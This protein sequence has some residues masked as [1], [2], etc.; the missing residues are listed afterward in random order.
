VVKVNAQ[1]VMTL[2]RLTDLPVLMCRDALVEADGDLQAAIRR[3]RASP[4]FGLHTSDEEVAA[5]LSLNG[6]VFAPAE[7]QPVILP[8]GEVVGAL[9][10]SGTA[11]ADLFLIDGLVCS[12]NA[13]GEL[14]GTRVDNEDLSASIKAFLR[15]SGVPEYP[16]LQA[17]YAHRQAEQNVAG[18]RGPQSS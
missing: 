13:Y 2:R 1:H 14:M 7:K 10:A 18:D 15:R 4:C 5:S 16:S 3:F 8:D 12:V 9:T 11:I 6:I 17:Y